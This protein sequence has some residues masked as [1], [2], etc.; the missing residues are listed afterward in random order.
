MALKCTGCQFVFK[1]DSKCQIHLI[2]AT[3]SEIL[4]TDRLFFASMPSGQ[5]IVTVREFVSSLAL[6]ADPSDPCLDTW[7]G[8]SHHTKLASKCCDSLTEQT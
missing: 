2:N 4:A 6:P 5:G 8:L 1:H 7:Q 3:Y